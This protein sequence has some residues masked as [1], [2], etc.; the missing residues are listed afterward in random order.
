MQ[1]QAKVFRRRVILTLMGEEYNE[2]VVKLQGAKIIEGG[3]I[4]AYYLGKFL[5][6]FQSTVSAVD[7]VSQKNLG[8]D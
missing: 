7:R 5:L 1:M 4:E 8:E 6:D 3:G 2:I